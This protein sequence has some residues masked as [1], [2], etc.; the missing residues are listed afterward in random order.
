MLTSAQ[1]S[2]H[3]PSR[4]PRCPIN[5]PHSPAFIPR[6]CTRSH[7][8]WGAEAHGPLALVPS[9]S[10]SQLLVSTR[11]LAH[12]PTRPHTHQQ[13][14]DPVTHLHAGCLPNGES[15]PI[16]VSLWCCHT[17]PP[18]AA[19]RTDTHP[20]TASSRP[21]ARA[22]VRPA[23][24]CPPRRSHA[25]SFRRTICTI[26]I[27]SQLSPGGSLTLPALSPPP[28]LAP[29]ARTDRAPRP[30]PPPGLPAPAS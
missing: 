14:M 18:S 9:T 30:L 13:V 29:L 26:S 10:S 6:Y 25:Q 23:T 12:A 20:R 22:Q 27:L 15:L 16:P 5:T 24:P 4:L 19:P 28:L 3:S 17:A 1:S 2:W 11:T 21:R 7:R 8:P